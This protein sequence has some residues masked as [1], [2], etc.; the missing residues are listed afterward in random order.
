MAQ[1]D[2]KQIRGASQGSILFLGTNSI[3]S[4]D[5]DKLNWDQSNDILTLNGATI[6]LSG[7]IR[8]FNVFK[9][10]LGATN[11]PTTSDDVSTGYSVGSEWID[12]SNN[13]SYNCL[14]S[15]TSSAIWVENATNTQVV[16]LQSQI[17]GLTPANQLISGGVSYTGSGFLYDVTIIN[18]KIQGVLYSTTATQVGLTAADPTLDRIDVV[19]VDDGQLVGVL[20][21]VPS[22]NPVKPNVDNATQLEVTFITVP[23]GQTTPSLT[24][25]IVYDENSGTASGEWDTSTD[26]SI[27]FASTNDP[28]S[29]TYSIET[30]AAFGSNKEIVFTPPGSLYTIVDSQLTFRLKGKVD[31]TSSSDAIFVGFYDSGLLVGNSVT[32]GGS[33]VSTFG[34]DGSDTTNYQLCAV[35]FSSFGGLPTTID[36]LRFFR[37]SGGGT[38]EFFLD[39]IQ[40]EE[41]AGSQPTA[42]LPSLSENNIW[43]GSSNSVAIEATFSFGNLTDTNIT[44]ATTNDTL[45]YDGTDWVN[46][47]GGILNATGS[48]GLGTYW[49]ST[50]DL[51]YMNLGVS[52]STG[53]IR[54]IQ[55]DITTQ[56]DDLTPGEISWNVND[57][58]LDVGLDNDV[59]LQLGQESHYRVKNQ[60]GATILDGRL[61][62]AVGTLGASGRI[63]ASYSVADGTVP[64]R[65]IIGV[66]TSNILNGADGY[67]T[68]F[69]LVRGI[70]ATGTPYGE[71]WTNGDIL[72]ANP[73]IVGGLTNQEPEPGGNTGVKVEVAIVVDA[74]AIGS[75]FVRVTNGFKLHEL[76]D[77]EYDSTLLT[78]DSILKWKTSGQYWT[79]STNSFE[80]LSDTNIISATT[81]DTLRYDGT[82]WVN[83]SLIT[84]DSNGTFSVNGTFIYT[85]GDQQAGYVLTSDGSGLASWSQSQGSTSSIGE[86][87][88]SGTQNGSNK[89]FVMSEALVTTQN[90]FFINGQLLTEPD[91]YVISGT[92][93]TIDSNYPAPISGDTL[94]L[95][96]TINDFAIIGPQGD[97]GATGA[98]GSQGI[99]GIQGETGA[100]GSQGIQGI[101]GET[102]AT[103]SQGIQGIQ[104][105]TGATG[106]QGIQ[107]IQGE[108][109][110]TG[111]TGSQ[112]IQ[113]IQGIQG[114]TGA[115]GATGA[116]S[117]IPGPT[118]PTGSSTGFSEV[119][120]NS[121]S[122][123]N[124]APRATLNFIEGPNVS[125]TIVDDSG[126][127]EVDITIESTAVGSITG[128]TAGSGLSGGG[129]QGFLQ[130]DLE[131]SVDK[132]L[133]FS[134]SGNAG[135]LE[136]FLTSNG[137]LTYS[138][139]GMSAF[140]D[141][142][143]IQIV[144]G[145]LTSTGGSG[146]I[147]SSV[148]TTDAASTEL[149]KIDTIVD[150]T[151][152]I[153][154]I[155]IKAYQS[156]G[157]QWGV[158][159]R[160]ITVT[161][162]SGTVTIQEV[163]ADVD[164]TSIGL[165][166]NDV[167]FNVNAGDIDVD[168]TGIVGTTIDW[169]SSYEIIL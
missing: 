66:A 108:I 92:A 88:I 68:E 33:P 2:I 96:G 130:M 57:G 49:S 153:I 60:T 160:T 74:V 150:N 71:T 11:S 53:D 4:E 22:L 106:S 8:G 152:N 94:R 162:T 14:D 127:D 79:H 12:I 158:W 15:S 103:G 84:A 28:F 21:G 137:G 23:A 168:V 120:L 163:N 144:N 52:Q 9:K 135:T 93:L 82:D 123:I 54:Y 125:L 44:S 61:V 77:V 42:G 143:T 27:D 56:N 30:T 43:I 118:G 129:T 70:D 101:Q 128:V 17:D 95:F 97:T 10:N 89:D 109:G 100:T 18:Y 169:E 157:S 133:T 20:T 16:N 40:I 147:E 161:K 145:Q 149:E 24:T 45:R 167:T 166:A 32:I 50:N 116:D 39:K 65:Y 59:T 25:I 119:S 48:T 3:V 142:T 72:W 46:I 113:G 87:V 78:D 37:T 110:A 83:N 156:G 47:S 86:I 13:K 148:Q 35:P 107:G 29:G 131:L 98:T 5:Y 134:T 151:T 38:G 141:N 105:E 69:G 112:G 121:G 62:S 63:S 19:Y 41:G 111:A 75:I 114:E 36:E 126:G 64:A 6:A 104:G 90:M 99:Q 73:N 164:K 34:F 51:N 67:V 76:H 136:T 7:D 154:K 81:N 31:M 117:V 132:G 102:G 159:T 1:Q 122:A 26:A 165:K 115:T 155:Y 80:N 55:F 139:G 124:L 85:D 58:T 140:V 91:D 146:R 138:G